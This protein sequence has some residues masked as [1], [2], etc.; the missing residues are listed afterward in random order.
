VPWMQINGKHGKKSK[1]EKRQGIDPSTMGQEEALV[2][3]NENHIL[4]LHFVD[5]AV[6]RIEKSEGKE[7]QETLI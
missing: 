2:I 5:S 3:E 4:A 7:S 6:E 1:D